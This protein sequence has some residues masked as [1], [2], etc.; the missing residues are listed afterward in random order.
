MVERASCHNIRTRLTV[1]RPTSRQHQDENHSPD[2]QQ[3]IS[4]GVG[5]GVP[6]RGDLAFSDI[7]NQTKRCGGS[8]RARNN[9]ERER[10]MESENVLSDEHAADQRHCCR[11]RTP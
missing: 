1:S 4:D 9:A 5:H 10:I 6:Q 7:T 2:R 3:G 8:P 11:N